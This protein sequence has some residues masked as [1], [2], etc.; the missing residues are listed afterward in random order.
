MSL[1]STLLTNLVKYTRTGIN[2]IRR[3]D[4]YQTLVLV[5]FK[6]GACKSQALVGMQVLG[7]S[8]SMQVLS[9]KVCLLTE[10]SI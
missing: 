3:W 4:H 9:H 5:V 2:I 10:S 8:E 1:E 7:Q 6:L